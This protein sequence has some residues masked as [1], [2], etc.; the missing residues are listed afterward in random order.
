MNTNQPARRYVSRYSNLQDGILAV[1][2]GAS[3]KK[4]IQ[5][6]DHK[7]LTRA[8]NAAIKW[9]GRRGIV[10]ISLLCDTILAPGLLIIAP[11][12]MESVRTIDG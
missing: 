3:K 2:S 7:A 8:R 9:M 11:R 1:N 5:Y 6:A 4:E 10:Q 12:E